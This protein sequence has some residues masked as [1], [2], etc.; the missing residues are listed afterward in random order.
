MYSYDHTASNLPIHPKDPVFW[1]DEKAGLSVE[2][3]S[4]ASVVVTEDQ[5]L[6]TIPEDP[7]PKEIGTHYFLTKEEAVVYADEHRPEPPYVFGH[8][9]DK[10][11]PAD[12]FIPDYYGWK[13]IQTTDE[14]G[15]VI[16]TSA[17]FD[18]GDGFV[19]VNEG[20]KYIGFFDGEQYE[21]EELEDVIA[22]T[23]FNNDWDTLEDLE[24]YE[25][26]H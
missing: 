8:D 1:L 17:Y 22:W 19:S 7:E 16:I 5:I 9:A 24:D 18:N 11:I 10:W 3:S 12:L 14:D 2:K 26:S 20:Q 4:V 21:S 25:W 23:D 6:L 15:D 13:Y